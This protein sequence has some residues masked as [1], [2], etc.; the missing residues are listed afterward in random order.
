MRKLIYMKTIFFVAI[1]LSFELLGCNSGSGDP[2]PPPPEELNPTLTLPSASQAETESGEI[3]SFDVKVSWVNGIGSFSATFGNTTGSVNVSGIAISFTSISTTEIPFEFQ[4]IGTTSA[5]ISGNGTVTIQVTYI[6]FGISVSETFILTVLG[7]PPPP[8]EICNNGI[9]DDG[10]NLVDCADPD[11]NNN[12]SCPPQPPQNFIEA[13]KHPL[14]KTVLFQ[15]GFPFNP[16]TGI[17]PT[18]A[19]LTTQ[20]QTLY[21]AGFLVIVTVSMDGTLREVPRIAKQIGFIAVG[22]G[23]FWFDEAQY[24]R[25]YMATIEEIQWID[26]IF[27]GREGLAFGRY[28]KQ[29]LIQRMDDLKTITGLPIATVEPTYTYLLDPEVLDIGDFLSIN[30]HPWIGGVKDPQEG[31]NFTLGEYN[32]IRSLLSDP[33]RFVHLNETWWPHSSLVGDPAASEINQAEY[34]TLLSATE[35][36]FLFGESFSQFWKDSAPEEP[37]FG[38]WKSDGSPNIIISNLQ[39]IFLIFEANHP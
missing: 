34:F 37:F 33:T 39:N 8:V 7:T 23:I 1:L 28:T 18:E 5:S 32:L 4:S 10:D 30:I 17:F 3:Y 19:Q 26:A 22:A 2:P 38:L 27:L 25:E 6:E 36:Y 11:C 16:E 21:D 15:A 35:I 31:V 24:Q 20:L 13:L 12:P 9:D 29:L 14:G